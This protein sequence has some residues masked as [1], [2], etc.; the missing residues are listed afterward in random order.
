[1]TETTPWRAVF[2]DTLT[3]RTLDVLPM[4]GVSME[5]RIGGGGSDG[6]G[7]L[8]GT[9]PTPTPEMAARAA[10]LDESR[11]TVYVYRGPELIWWAGIV[12]T[13]EV[14]KDE[15]GMTSLDVQAASLESA[16]H[17]RIID[18]TITPLA[19]VDQ[20]DIARTLLDHMQA[21]P[22][23]NLGI[24]A[25]TALSGVL[26]DRTEYKRSA[27]KS[28]GEALTELASVEGGFEFRILAFAKADGTR[29]KRF[30]L[31]YPT[32]GRTDGAR[33]ILSDPGNVVSWRIQRDRSRGATHTWARGASVGDDQTVADEPLLSSIHIAQDL[34]DVGQPRR[35]A[36]IDRH[37]VEDVATLDA[38]AAGEL[39]RRRG[40]VETL[41]IRTRLDDV[42]I[43]IGRA[44]V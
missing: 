8:R 12:Q 37:T 43:K 26:R 1:M 13:L 22:A 11:T 36:V 2:A 40:A 41:T 21:D 33:W 35:D 17:G 10:E 24:V 38:W 9:V 4:V 18:S 3:D 34:I 27:A 30:V 28:Y 20:L 23:S 44:H 31:G 5:A 16:L 42:G 15:Q 7:T 14:A 29:S 25:D 6:I 39:E 32:L 19:D